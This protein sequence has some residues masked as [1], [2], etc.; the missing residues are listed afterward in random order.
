LATGAILSKSN[1]TQYCFDSGSASSDPQ[2][3]LCNAVVR[4]ETPLEPIINESAINRAIATT[5]A[6]YGLDDS[7]RAT[8]FCESGLRTDV[9]SRGKIS[10][11]IAQFRLTTWQMFNKIKKTDMDYENPFDQIDM[12][13]WAFN[14]GYQKHWDCYRMLFLGEKL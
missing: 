13:G 2:L 12:M 6:K 4:T 1:S 3:V 14:K 7:F 8:L 11:G 9:F 5:K 10:Y